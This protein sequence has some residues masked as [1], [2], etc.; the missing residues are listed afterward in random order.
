VARRW[1]RAVL[2]AYQDLHSVESHLKTAAAD[3][4]QL[5]DRYR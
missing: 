1:T 2:D 4:D 5:V 3:I